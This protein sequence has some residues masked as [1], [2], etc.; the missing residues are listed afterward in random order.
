MPL[1]VT[2]R[3]RFHC[4]KAAGKRYLSGGCPRETLNKLGHVE[5]VD[6]DPAQNGAVGRQ[7]CRST[8]TAAFDNVMCKKGAPQQ[9]NS[10]PKHFVGNALSSLTDNVKIERTGLGRYT[11][12]LCRARLSR[13]A[14]TLNPAQLAA[15]RYVDGPLLVLAG[16]GSGKTRVITLKIAHLV[17]RCGYAPENVAAITFT[18]KAARE[19]RERVAA[20]APGKKSLQALTLCTFHALG[21]K[22]LRSEATHLGLKPRFS[23]LD[24][25]D[26]FALLAQI[27][28][29][30]D[31]Q[32]V[33]RV[34]WQISSWKNAL[35]SPETAGS[36]ATDA[37]HATAARAYQQYD[38]TLRAYQAVDFDDLILLP[39]RL[40][41]QDHTTLT[42]WRE[43]LRY[44]LIDEYQDTND[45]QYR[46]LRLLCGDTG[47][48]TA[49]GDDDQAIYAW[50]GA[51]VENLQ[52]LQ[53][54][55]PRLQIIK[56]E[57]NYRSTT[58]ILKAANSLIAH[59][60]KMFEKRLWSELGAGELSHV[61]SMRDDEYEAESIVM[62][63]AAHKLQQHTRFS[64]YAI[65]YRGN[66]Q[67]RVFEQ[68]LR[69]QRIPYRV[70]GG[71]SFF[72]RAEI[73]D[74]TAYLR[75]IVNVDD[76]PA[77]IRA[78]TTP[79][80]GIGAQTL[81]ALGAYA[82]ERK[83]SMFEAAFE[84]G[85][86]QRLKPLQL[87]P[88]RTF[89]EF[90]NR[91]GERAESEAAGAVLNDLVK[92]IEYQSY[93]VD[94]FESRDSENRWDNVQKFVG[95]LAGKAVVEDKTLIELTQT[96][97]LMNMLEGR[98]DNSD[99]VSLSTIHAAKGLE[100]PYVFLVGIEEHIL[101][102]RESVDTGKIEE[103]RRLMYVAITRARTQL[104][105]S[106]CLK[107]RR[108]KEWHS[109]EPSRFIAE[110]G[111]DNVRLNGAKRDPAASQAEG[112]NNIAALRALLAGKQEDVLN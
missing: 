47:H 8:A 98:D 96:V 105:V 110:M 32:A 7:N 79:R 82:G 83:V 99:A 88:L 40:F 68:Q 62:R 67:A 106:H 20:M 19:M 87:A 36:T 10:A 52:T 74:L 59:N 103:E 22:I 57:Q 90:I 84:L 112:L 69:N 56:L 71:Q 49:V 45:A 102:H 1:P 55:Y 9:E 4:I 81:E 42:R 63:I 14:I 50:R 100:F 95:W 5:T 43:K 76:D 37:Q 53:I 13:M 30:V 77:F 12:A 27:L 48:F 101:P 26:A 92:A 34:Q 16:A 78:I 15:V 91:M 86:E 108:G 65:L 75:L 33:R 51:S 111:A 54:D 61:T 28:G 93:L 107:R 39:V 72:E 29:S 25:D 46:L 109:C 58:R 80:R 17:S 94:N 6:A 104:F 11:R 21:M 89:C 70:S 35:A 66:H 97:A 85:L 64:D 73:K 18:N 23:V 44:V 2:D 3:L 41:S 24:A 31:K 60:P 38:L